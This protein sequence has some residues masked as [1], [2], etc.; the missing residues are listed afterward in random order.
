M[1]VIRGSPLRVTPGPEP[2]GLCNIVLN[3]NNSM[4]RSFSPTRF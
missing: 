1:G 2:P 3:F 4:I